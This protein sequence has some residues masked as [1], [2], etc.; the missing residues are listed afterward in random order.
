MPLTVQKQNKETSQSLIRRFSQKMRRSGIVLEIR[1][2]QFRNKPQ[3]RPLVKLSALRRI[4]K[5]EEYLEKQ[6]MGQA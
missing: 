1:R 2:R 3:S 4:A 5:N 6:K